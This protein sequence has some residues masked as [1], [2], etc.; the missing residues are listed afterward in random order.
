MPMTRRR[1]LLAPTALAASCVPGALLAAVE[2]ATPA[3]PDLGSWEAVRAQFALDPSWRH[4][5]SF[6]ISSHPAPVRQALEAFRQAIDANP[7]LYVEQA[8]FEGEEHNLPLRVC[9]AA[10]GYLGGRPEEVCLVRSTTEAL[11]LVYLG[12]PLRP[13]D[14]VLC[15]THD[16]YSHHE[17]IRLAVERAGAT[18]RKIAL[19]DDPAEASVDAMVGRLR[20]AIG[21]RTRVVGV[22]WVHSST[23]VRLPVRRIAQALR[24]GGASPLLVVDGVH[25]LGAA[26]DS[27]A[28]MGADFFCAGTHKW[29]FAPRGT[30]LVWAHAE[31]WARLRP[32]VPSFSEE[33][34]YMA[35]MQGRPPA[36][37]N[38]AARMTP[39]GFHAYEHQWAMAAAFGMH[40]AMG[41]ERVAARIRALNDRLKA[42]MA[43]IPGV[44][45]RTP[46]DGALSAGLVCFE[47]EGLPAER[48]VARL[49]QKRIVAS[50]SPYATAYARLA[51]SLVN[52]EQEVDEA[53]G[54]LQSIAGARAARRR[55]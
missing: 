18:M 14:E 32:M 22:T 33:E 48:T 25:G 37:P 45:I 54:A 47:V 3:L 30:G 53:I 12:L 31:A 41:R 17:S 27:V 52:S 42:G 15:T 2:A 34:A 36:T 43:Q 20:A 49:L 7:F 40:A 51:P 10:A 4:F 23:G 50:V 44:R 5:S 55:G 26:D 24:E 35:W 19:Y 13:G 1:F 16:H 6:F 29:M 21:P 38:N 8:L 11:A 28:A 46:M 9:E 39:G